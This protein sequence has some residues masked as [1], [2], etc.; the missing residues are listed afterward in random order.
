LRLQKIEK[1]REKAGGDEWQLGVLLT[2]DRAK[3]R[4]KRQ[5][6]GFMEGQGIKK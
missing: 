2:L 4:K 1:F 3:H 5:M 6:K